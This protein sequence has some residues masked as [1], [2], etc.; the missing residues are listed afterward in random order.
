LAGFVLVGPAQGWLQVVPGV[1]LFGGMLAST[2]FFVLNPRAIP[3]EKRRGAW[4]WS[5]WNER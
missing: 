1:L 5:D 4:W 3:R 2:V